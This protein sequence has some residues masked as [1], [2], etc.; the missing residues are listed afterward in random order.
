VALLPV[1]PIPLFMIY[2]VTKTCIQGPGITSWEKFKYTLISP[3]RYEVVKPTPAPR[4]SSNA[5]GYVLLPQAPL[6]E[7]EPFNE[8][9]HNERAVRVSN[10]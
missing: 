7:P 2:I 10:I 1:L 8:V 6:A 5:P 4:Y 9:Y 3:L